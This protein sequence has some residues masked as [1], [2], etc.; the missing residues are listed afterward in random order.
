MVGH[1]HED[2]D[3]MF[4]CVSRRIRTA[5]V[6]TLPQLKDLIGASYKPSPNVL[7]LRSIFNTRDWLLPHIDATFGHS[8]QHQ[9]KFF[10]AE[11]GFPAVRCKKWSFSPEWL[12]KGPPLRVLMTAPKSLPSVQQV[13]FTKANLAKMEVL[14]DR[15]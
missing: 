2:V 7:I 12:P 9:F 11:D 6:A 8:D 3:Q 13:D 10:L 5:N 15:R 14:P 1:T 4:S